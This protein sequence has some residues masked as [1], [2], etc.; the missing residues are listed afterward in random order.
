MIKK[1]LTDV[2]DRFLP[3]ISKKEW[4]QFEP[5]Y[6]QSLQFHKFEPT[7]YLEG[8]QQILHED[9][10]EK[11]DGSSFLSFCF[12]FIRQLPQHDSF[13]FGRN[14]KIL[15]QFQPSQFATSTFL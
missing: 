11:N 13:E 12:P 10:L 4:I 6:N 3:S 15:N 1:Y 14:R 7:A 9:F 5:N 2:D 8:K